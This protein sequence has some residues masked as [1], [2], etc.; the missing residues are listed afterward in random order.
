MI[1]KI[2]ADR[3]GWTKK[4]GGTENEIVHITTEVKDEKVKQ[5]KKDIRD[6]NTTAQV[7]V[8]IK[9]HGLSNIKGLPE[10]IKEVYEK[11]EIDKLKTSDVNKFALNQRYND[12]AD[13][14][15]GIIGV[16]KAINE[17]N[18][19]LI[20]YEDNTTEASEGTTKLCGA[21]SQS[22]SSLGKYL[23]GLNGATAGMGKY[24]LSLTTA[25]LK[26]FALKTATM[27]LNMAV[28]MGVSFAISGIITAI[29]NYVNSIDNAIEASHKAKET[30]DEA[31]STLK[32][33]QDMIKESGKKYAELAQHVNQLNNTNLD[34]HEDEYKS[35]LELSNQIAEQFP[36]LVKGYDENGN[37]ILS[38]NG[39]VSDINSTLD[40]YIE[41][42]KKA[43]QVKIVQAFKGEGDNED[44]FKGAKYE[45][46]ELNG[47]V[48]NAKTEI[49][50]LQKFK[51]KI[52][53]H[54]DDLTDQTSAD[55]FGNYANGTDA[56]LKSDYVRK[57]L[58]DSGLDKKLNDNSFLL[59]LSKYLPANELISFNKALKDRSIDGR[60]SDSAI[61]TIDE[62]FSKYP[63]KSGYD[64][65]DYIT[66]QIKTATDNYEQFAK[67]VETKNKEISQ[68]AQAVLE[69]SVI[70]SN[71]DTTDQMKTTMTNA[72][73]K[74]D[75]SDKQF[76]GFDGERAANYIQTT[77]ASS[78][79]KLSADDKITVDKF[80]SAD[81]NQVDLTEYISLYEKTKSI[82]KKKGIKIPIN[83]EDSKKVEDDFNKSLEQMSDKDKETV[84][85]YLADNSIDSA[86]KIDIWNKRTEGITNAKDAIE[87]YE[88]KAQ[89]V[90]QISSKDTPI[91]FSKA[92]KSIGTSGD[93][94]ADKVALEEKD[95]LLEL[96]EAGKLTKKEFESS[97]ISDS[98]LKQTGLDAEEAT[99]KINELVEETKQLSA[100]RT[101]ITTIT[102]AYD[103]K[104]DSKKK[105]VSSSTLDSM[106][107]TLG[108]ADWKGKDLEVWEN[109]K[110]IA[111]DGT[112]GTKELKEAQDS[113][114]TSFV[115]NGNYLANLTSE[116]K[117]YY[118]SLLEE[119][120]VTNASQ[121]IQQQLI[122]N[123]DKLT[124]K[125]INAKL[126]TLELK[127]ATVNEATALGNELTGLY[128]SSE[129]LGLYVLKKQLANKNA[130]KTSDSIENLI[131]LAKQCG[132]TGKAITWL[133]Y[134]Q[135]N[136]AKLEN[137]K[138]KGGGNGA[139]WDNT[140]KEIDH[141]QKL[142]TKAANK[143]VKIK[144]TTTYGNKTNPS[145]KSDGGKDKSK[146]NS[147]QEIDWIERRVNRLISII[148]RLNA[149]KENLFSVKKKNSN[150]K[151]QIKET[152]KLINTYGAAIKKYDKKA[153]SIKLSKPLKKLVENGKIKGSYKT[154]V[155]KYGEK[156]A[157]K[158]QSYQNWYDKS[159]SAKQSLADAKKQKRELKKEQYQNYVD[160]Y[161][162]RVSRAE[163]NEA[164][165]IGYEKKNKSVDT[166]IDNLKKSYGYQ[167]KI[168]KK[169]EKN[170][171]EWQKLEYEREKKIAELR[172]QQI[173]N[174]QQ[175]YENR[176]G[177]T[178]N[179]RENIENAISLAEARGKIVTA[180]YYKNQ[181]NL[182]YDKRAKAVEEKNK[183]QNSLN[184]AI[185][186]GEIKVYSDEWYEVQSKLHTLEN[187]INECDVTIANNTR[188]IREVHTAMLDEMAENKN[189]INTEADF[190][191]GLMSRK[192]M[193]DSDTGTLTKE[194]FG[195]LGAY[196]IKMETS[197]AHI[198]ELNEERAILEDMKKKGI[199]DFGDGGE[200]KYDSLEDFEKYYNEL[201]QKQQEWVKT[202]YD[203]EQ[204]IIDLMKEYYQAQIDYMKDIIDAKKKA[205]DLE[206]D[207]YNYQKNIAEK[208]KNIALLE[209][210]AAAI[211]GDT[212]E[213]GRA[214]LAK[215]QLSL[216][217]ANQDLQDTEYDR[218]IS[219]Q[220]DMLDNM[221][222][223]YEDLMQRLF[224][225]TDA[226]LRDGIA[227]INENG[228]VIKGIMDKTA[229]DYN[230]DYSA[231]FNAIMTAFNTGQPIVTGIKES[232]TGDESSI[233]GILAEQTETIKK[234]YEDTSTSANG[235]GS[236]NK[237]ANNGN[238]NGNKDFIINKDDIYSNTVIDQYGNRIN[239]GGIGEF[240]KT[241]HKISPY[242]NAVKGSPKSALNKLLKK[243]TG[244]YIS[245]KNKNADLK[246]ISKALGVKYDGKY[247]KGGAV[248]KYL[249][250]HGFQT[251][252]IVRANNVPLTGDYVP[253]R[254][255]PNETILTQ[256]F[257]DMLPQAVNVMDNLQKA[258]RVP[259][260]T[261]QIVKNDAG[262]SY[263]DIH[264]DIDLPNVTNSSTA[265]DIIHALQNDTKVQQ[266][267][268]EGVNNLM[269]QKRITSNI[270]NLR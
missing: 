60:L 92:W 36:D 181:N 75:W 202:E 28:S 186:S 215:I 140:L 114:A 226:L 117:E 53:L 65:S 225:D 109:Y 210:Q 176:I 72:I 125:K 91:S 123:E 37:A 241:L 172:L 212:S 189:R 51:K 206:K 236:D 63:E 232:L 47:K 234:I 115:N 220:Q 9:E 57:Y 71:P 30:M 132:L 268:S 41:K 200:H 27:A 127:S 192:E 149:E 263:G 11:G 262:T 165:E 161:N 205:L 81:P 23:T 228:A 129:A 29:I 54:K 245:D 162:S 106:G 104:K 187:T 122:I 169:L 13:Q 238:N 193:T 46:D 256:K 56:R 79:E 183:I 38:L 128:G 145:G 52:D 89:E 247:T 134:L 14:A 70:W 266:V 120:G 260:Y 19:S 25:A 264:F 130:L 24:A 48:T 74:I 196:G 155:K 144:P 255:N 150:L 32:S 248:Y 112:K 239:N 246:S 242:L 159:E 17:Y 223:E 94:D 231:N 15:H 111:A 153:D 124:T 113:L 18:E 85:K 180:G 208:T 69:Q 99:R 171:A 154:L 97:Y 76:E 182:T 73:G 20:R 214:R 96:A 86:S 209:K 185:K 59:G 42:A 147:K 116:K 173:N 259:N 222:A 135:A 50:N 95:K 243:K 98:F 61:L 175:D 16:K 44:Y 141:Y 58:E 253:V 8:V 164:K 131:A 34:L 229:E 110:N 39:T 230:Y 82:F 250:A 213:E 156:T 133:G 257:T 195:T 12:I 2:L 103:E 138:E 84:K 3:W 235:S 211:K 40:T 136:Q 233:A 269:K 21:I 26:T 265:K 254:V 126:A 43:S 217:E 4:L 151:K 49:E 166:Q 157:N 87:A 62:I 93:E 83:I 251:G 101:G 142:V 188:A 237:P 137:L 118:K 249:K 168:A 227:A 90:S 201:I 22:N 203:A 197:Q 218:Y 167:I 199:L 139:E 219:D 33:Q 78:F 240:G 55:L 35:F 191:A 121:I 252:G 261:R 100:L 45:V 258:I 170:K 5:L 102:S 107:D 88:K 1:G 80:F 270:R 178:E 163:A 190:I 198:R 31:N 221:Y 77:F 67:D 152:T 177:L 174:I 207:L 108:V 160:L 68:N 119:M 194:G 64:I 146:S 105:V 244:S 143:K 148:S 179:E 204:G 224:K 267:F 216:D 184:D 66:Q 6:C 158:I 10:H 7:D